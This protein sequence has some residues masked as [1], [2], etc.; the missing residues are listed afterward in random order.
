VRNPRLLRTPLLDG[1]RYVDG[2][3]RS[4]C[5]LDLMAGL[6][7]DLVAVSAPMSTS[8][9]IDRSRDSGWRSAAR[10]QLEREAKKV[11]SRGTPVLLLHP[12]A[13]VR[14]AMRGASMDVSRRPTIAE[15][16]RDSALAGLGSRDAALL[17]RLRGA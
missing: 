1:V 3:V 7:L 12:N 13:R 4:L 10:A 9:W 14:A 5:N 8:R 11:R 16:V 2:G 6:G 17:R 15:L